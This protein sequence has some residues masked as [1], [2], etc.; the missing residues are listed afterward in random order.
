MKSIWRTI[1]DIVFGQEDKPLVSDESMQ[2]LRERNQIRAQEKIKE[3][4]SKWLL[5]PDNH[6]RSKNERLQQTN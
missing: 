1:Q 2:E 5:H 3:M 4:G 6:T